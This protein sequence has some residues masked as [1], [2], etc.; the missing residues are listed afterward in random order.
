MDYGAAL[1]IAESKNPFGANATVRKIDDFNNGYVFLAELPLNSG[2]IPDKMIIA[3]HDNGKT[4]ASVYSVEDA[5]SN[6]K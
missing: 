5:I 1:K 3:V 4:G 2:I 6:I